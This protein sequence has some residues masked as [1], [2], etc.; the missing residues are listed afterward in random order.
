MPGQKRYVFRGE[1]LGIT[2]NNKK[3]KSDPKS[4]SVS[5]FYFS[6]QRL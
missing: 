3:S 4:D 1:P 6:Q 5:V 2:T